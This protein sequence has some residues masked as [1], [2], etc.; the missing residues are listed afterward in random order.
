MIVVTDDFYGGEAGFNSILN[1]YYENAINNL[2]EEDRIKARRFIEEGLIVGERRVGMTEGVERERYKIDPYLIDVLLDSRLIRAEVT[3]LGRSFEVSHDTL[4]EPIVR[5]KKF[6]QE[7][8]EKEKRLAELRKTRRRYFIATGI[9]LTGIALAATSTLFFFQANTNLNDY[10]KSRFQG[11][12]SAFESAVKA[13]RTSLEAG[14]Y[15]RATAEFRSAIQAYESYQEET[16]TKSGFPAAEAL[17]SEL[18][19]NIQEINQFLEAAA[20]NIETEQ[21]FNNFVARAQAYE[22]DGGVNLLKAREELAQAN[23]LNIK[24]ELL[25]E[26]QRALETQIDN[27]YDRFILEGDRS[28]FQGQVG[29]YRACLA[30]RKAMQLRPNRITKRI[31][32]RIEAGGC[33]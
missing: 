7:Q 9:A 1:N 17:S 11:A 29:E 8:E 20:A 18:Q 6:R 31:R 28:F 25:I 5:S 24:Q 3:H 32:G 27:T 21:Q 4:I 19:V 14:E 23:R 26:L 2:P 16:N 15:S 33:E 10:I 12:K 22:K 13:G 30:Y